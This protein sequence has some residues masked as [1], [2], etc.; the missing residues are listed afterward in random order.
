VPANEPSVLNRSERNWVRSIAL[1]GQDGGTEACPDD[2][3]VSCANCNATLGTWHEIQD[4]ERPMVS[5]KAEQVVKDV[6]QAAVPSWQ[7][8]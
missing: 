5:N 2:A 7:I 1:A 3:S 4:A 6:L 8:K